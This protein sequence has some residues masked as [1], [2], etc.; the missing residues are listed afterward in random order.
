MGQVSDL[1]FESFESFLSLLPM[2]FYRRRLPHWQPERVPTFLTWRLYGSL[3]R[4][5]Q[6]VVSDSLTEGRRFLLLD[7]ELDSANSGPT[8]LRHP[9]VAASVAKTLFIAGRKWRLYELIAWVV[10]R[11][12]V[13]VLLRPHKLL[14]EVTRAV[15]NTSA[16]QANLILGRTGLR[17]W[18][19]ESY[20]HWVRDSNELERIVRYLEW[21]TVR[22]GLVE[23][24]E[25]WPWSSA[26]ETT[27]WQVGDLPHVEQR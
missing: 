13:H 4:A 12:H 6:T 19:D 1:P 2:S 18:Q 25:L 24:A 15:K 17:F 10:M 26:S 3:P 7:R 22:A 9:R 14:R 11:N 16:R 23:P 5:N 20:D 8:F 21:N 27:L